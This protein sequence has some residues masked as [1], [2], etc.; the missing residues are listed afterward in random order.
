MKIISYLF[1]LQKLNLKNVKKSFSTTK[2]VDLAYFFVLF[3]LVYRKI[4]NFEDMHFLI[5]SEFRQKL[6][7]LSKFYENFRK[8]HSDVEFNSA[9]DGLIDLM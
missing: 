1:K 5:V 8:N 3:A 4:N 6:Q 2:S 9:F 7:N